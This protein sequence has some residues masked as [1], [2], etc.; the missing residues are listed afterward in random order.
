MGLKDV[1]LLSLSAAMVI[2]G[3]H[4]TMTQGILFSYPVF[5]ASVALLLWF[6]FRKTGQTEEDKKKDTLNKKKRN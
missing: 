5:M 1:I 3:T 6:K 2:V 4:I